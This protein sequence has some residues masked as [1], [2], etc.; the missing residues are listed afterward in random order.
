MWALN[1]PVECLLDTQDVES[2]TLSAPT[3]LISLG[4]SVSEVS[5]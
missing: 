4:D 5:S 1:S 3:I 2:S